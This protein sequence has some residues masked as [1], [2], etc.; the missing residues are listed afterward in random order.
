MEDQNFPIPARVILQGNPGLI[1]H[2]G[3]VVHSGV[4]PVFLPLLLLA[5]C[6]I[7]HRVS[8]QEHQMKASQ[9]E[10][11]YPVRAKK[12]QNLGREWEPPEARSDQGGNSDA[13]ITPADRPKGGE[14][15]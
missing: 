11:M 9:A 2:V 1:R 6:C 8:L 7:G 5:V 14:A 13:G 10:G 3:T 4:L 15:A 12:V